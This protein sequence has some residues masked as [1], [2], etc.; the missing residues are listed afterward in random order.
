M[1]AANGTAR[2]DARAETR[3]T[4]ETGAPAESTVPVERAPTQPAGRRRGL[5]PAREA[6]A[7]GQGQVEL[8]IFRLGGELFAIDLAAVDEAA[9][10]DALHRVPEMPDGVLG[11]FNLRG[12]L[13]PAHSPALLLGI[14]QAGDPRVVLVTTA[15]DR[16][17]G[18]AVS[19]I[20]DVAQLDVAA[21]RRPPVPDGGGILLGVA[22]HGAELIGIIDAGALVAACVL[23]QFTEAP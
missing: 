3:V 4:A 2:A 8:L 10:L 16:R 23:P 9:E 7:A 14:A 19:D 22:K 15:G 1:S 18:L 12:R 6:I 11:V 21:V 20:E 17:V 13:V 5:R